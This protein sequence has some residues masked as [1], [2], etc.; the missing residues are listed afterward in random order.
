MPPSK[1]GSKEGIFRE[2]VRMIVM[3]TNIVPFP[4][5]MSRFW[6]VRFSSLTIS[7]RPAL[8]MGSKD[9][10]RIVTFHLK[11]NNITSPTVSK[12]NVPDTF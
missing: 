3:E 10:P 8:S 5:S 11:R 6:N 1:G 2:K 12:R 7:P 4:T 9:I